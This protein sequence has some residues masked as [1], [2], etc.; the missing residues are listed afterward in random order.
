M[1]DPFAELCATL[2]DVGATLRFHGVPVTEDQMRDIASRSAVRRI[3]SRFAPPLESGS[4][5]EEHW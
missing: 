1:K 4:T 5:I 3:E 2:R